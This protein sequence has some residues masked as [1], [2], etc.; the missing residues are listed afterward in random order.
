MSRKKADHDLTDAQVRVLRALAKM[1]GC[2]LEELGNKMGL[3]YG[4][5]VHHRRNL[6]RAGYITS[7]PGKARTT[8]LTKSARLTL[9]LE[10]E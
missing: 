9:G 1:P 5:I 3:A 6:E 2:S 10:V 4:T 7:S 8:R